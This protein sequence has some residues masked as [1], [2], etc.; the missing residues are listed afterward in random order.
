[1]VVNNWVVK[2]RNV[3]ICEQCNGSMALWFNKTDRL[4]MLCCDYCD[5]EHCYTQEEVERTGTLNNYI[6]EKENGN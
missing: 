4:Y 1:M 3:S 5:N 2:E 6:K